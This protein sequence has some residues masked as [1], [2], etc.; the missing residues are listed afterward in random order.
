[1]PARRRN[2]LLDARARVALNAYQIAGATVWTCEVLG[3]YLLF[4]P[5][6]EDASARLGVMIAYGALAMTATC[7]FFAAAATDPKA[8]VVAGDDGKDDDD[9]ATKAKM[10]YCRFCEA[11]VYAGAKHCRDCDK[12]VDGFDHHC[13]WLNNCVGVKNYRSFFV[14]VSATFTQ[15]SGQVV[16]GAYVLGWC[17]SDVDRAK[18]YIATNASYV[19]R[20]VTYASL[21]GGI[22]AYMALGCG[23]LYIV[24]E[25]LT[26]HLALCYKGI[27]TYDY[28]IAERA[29]AADLRALAVE[30]GEDP[31]DIVVRTNVCRL[32]YLDEAYAPEKPSA[33]ASAPGTARETTKSAGIAVKKAA[34]AQVKADKVKAKDTTQGA[35]QK[36]D[37]SPPPVKRED[38]LGEFDEELQKKSD[39]RGAS[40]KIQQS[41]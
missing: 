9:D 13:K 33:R 2:G 35:G 41:Q 27:S 3:F 29:I 39:A 7:A 20:G 10:L 11:T 31:T 12:C 40:R 32:C 34:K 6:V 4:V 36:R 22:C 16:S 8:R 17:A 28:I 19:G 37:E 5:S 23:L 21:I 24:G 18:A 38:A 25:L 26:F 1:M 14:L 15:V 30:Q